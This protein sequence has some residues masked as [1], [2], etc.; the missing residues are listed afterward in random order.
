MQKYDQQLQELETLLCKSNGSLIA[1]E[2]Y[3]AAILVFSSI[4][5][6]WEPSDLQL[7][8]KITQEWCLPL[9]IVFSRYGGNSE[10]Y[11]NDPKTNGTSELE[12]SVDQDLVRN[13]ITDV[14][15]FRVN[16]IE[17]MKDSTVVYPVAGFEK[18][19]KG[20]KVLAEKGMKQT[21]LRIKDLRMKKRL[22]KA[23]L[24]IKREGFNC[25][26]QKRECLCLKSSGIISNAV[27]SKKMI[28]YLL[29]LFQVEGDL[30][31]T[32]AELFD[33]YQEG[34]TPRGGGR[35]VTFVQKFESWS[36]CTTG[37]S[38]CEVQMRRLGLQ[39]FDLLKRLSQTDD[40]LQTTTILSAI[41]FRGN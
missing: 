30:V 29:K 22:N 11:E 13:N 36:D 16:S 39:I 37:G 5:A 32:A 34:L 35:F 20:L 38:R 8:K 6:K 7:V 14:E 18:L 19:A 1:S 2:H 27:N 10:D 3:D 21:I 23:E 4:S 25:G 41:P 9:S 24:I 28:E 12:S 15:F 26:G 31:K 33:A 17:T 40:R